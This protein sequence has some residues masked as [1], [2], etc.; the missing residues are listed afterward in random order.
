MT[1]GQN[2]EKYRKIKEDKNCY[3]KIFF[4]KRSFSFKFFFVFSKFN[5]KIFI[6]FQSHPIYVFIISITILLIF[7]LTY[8]ILKWWFER[9]KIVRKKHVIALYSSTNLFHSL[10][11]LHIASY[12]SLLPFIFSSTFTFSSDNKLII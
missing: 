5:V 10:A 9:E 3:I 4:M 8:L 2:I 6:L 12:Y 7:S 11:N 1:N